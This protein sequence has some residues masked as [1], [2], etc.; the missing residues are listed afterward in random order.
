MWGV[1]R[2]RLQIVCACVQE[3]CERNAAIIVFFLYRVSASIG[4]A[5]PLLGNPTNGMA[6]VAR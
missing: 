5:L 6:V 3:I 2:A 4:A 1:N